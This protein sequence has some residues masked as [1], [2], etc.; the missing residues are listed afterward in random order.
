V[1]GL[2]PIGE[3]AE[4]VNIGTLAAFTVVCAGVILL[5]STKPD[6]PRPFKLPFGALIPALGIIFCLYLMFSLPWITWLRFVVWMAIGFVVYFAY[7]R[8]HSKLNQGSKAGL[9]PEAYTHA[10]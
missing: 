7:G 10:S 6:M 1:A 5:R 4:L 9:A 3:L 2:T 8:V